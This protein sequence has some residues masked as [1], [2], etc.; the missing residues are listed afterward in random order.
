MEEIER[1]LNIHDKFC[2]RNSQ[3]WYS[4]ELNLYYD[5][6]DNK[7]YHTDGVIYPAPKDESHKNWILSHEFID[8]N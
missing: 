1:I 8:Y 2:K 4:E 5:A 6:L 3:F 7:F